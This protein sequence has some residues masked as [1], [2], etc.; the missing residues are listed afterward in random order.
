MNYGKRP[1]YPKEETP[2]PV[3]ELYL[4]DFKGQVYGE[5]ME[6]E[7]HRFLRPE[8]KF[9]TEKAL[10]TKIRQDVE[11]ARYYYKNKQE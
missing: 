8:Q 7:L 1:T 2:Q 5:M 3:L 9:S 4:L 11:K 6:I 10:I